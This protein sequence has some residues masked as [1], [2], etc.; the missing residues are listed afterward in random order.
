MG[1]MQNK[2]PEDGCE[3]SSRRDA[4][5]GKQCFLRT[6]TKLSKREKDTCSDAELFPTAQRLMM[7]LAPQ[8]TVILH[9]ESGKAYASSVPPSTVLKRHGKHMKT[10]ISLSVC[11]SA[12]SQ[13]PSSSLSSLLPALEKDGSSGTKKI[14]SKQKNRKSSSTSLHIVEE[15]STEKGGTSILTGGE[16]EGNGSSRRGAT[17]LM[18]G[19]HQDHQEKTKQASNRSTSKAKNKNTFVKFKTKEEEKMDMEREDKES[20]EDRRAAEE[21][22]RRASLF[23]HKLHPKKQ[24][25]FWSLREAA[26]GNEKKVPA[27]RS[28]A[29]CSMGSMKGE[30]AK[31]GRKRYRNGSPDHSSEYGHP[32]KPS[33]RK[34]SL[35]EKKEQQF[36]NDNDSSRTR[37]ETESSSD[38]SSSEPS[39]ISESDDEDEEEQEKEADKGNSIELAK[40]PE[41]GRGGGR[42][43]STTEQWS[44]D[45]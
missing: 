13:A 21:V 20:E 19:S 16:N 3:R 37:C 26:K 44:D 7:E 39:W 40:G 28:E 6:G 36:R 29:Q 18:K 5:P 22:L 24:Q 15:P 41:N 14:A 32:Q 12:S 34:F 31:V 10:A 33:K 2:R 38:D 43:F 35:V 25:V 42:L 1:K 27:N 45:E 8:E 4:L 11:G 23:I 30:E 9:S 17:A